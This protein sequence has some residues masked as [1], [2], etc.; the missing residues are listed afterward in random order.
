MPKGMRLLIDMKKLFRV[1]VVLLFFALL[2]LLSGYWEKSSGE[3]VG[4]ITRLER[5]GF[6]CKTWE[7]EIGNG[8]R[9][10]IEEEGLVSSARKFMDTR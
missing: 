7:A 10:T 4:T 2:P 3:K 9:F 8:F 5:T 1:F 6:F